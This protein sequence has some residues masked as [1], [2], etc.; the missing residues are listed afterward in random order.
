MKKT[1]RITTISNGHEVRYDTKAIIH[2]N[3]IIYVEKDEKKTKTYFNYD[4]NQ[5]IRENKEL[6]LKYNFDKNKKTT[7]QL[8]VYELQKYVTLKIET[9]KL[10][11][12]EYNIEIDFMVENEPIKYKIEVIK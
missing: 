2:D 11:R 7:G 9:K 3:S 1:V 10:V 5:L 6:S 4:K 12:F 8:L